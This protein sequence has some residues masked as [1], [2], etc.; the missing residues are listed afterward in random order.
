MNTLRSDPKKP[1]ALENLLSA[2]SDF[3]NTTE[4]DSPSSRWHSG[5]GGTYILT[6]ISLASSTPIPLVWRR[7]GSIGSSNDEKNQIQIS[8][9]TTPESIPL[10]PWK[11]IWTAFGDKW[12]PCPNHEHL[13]AEIFR[14]V[15]RGNFNASEGLTELNVVVKEME[16]CPIC[17]TKNHT[18]T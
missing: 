10:K 11:E 12:S 15:D 13:V 8:L 16:K 6:P 14:A 2:I 1:T 9:P 5:G 3:V 17:G 18:T 7:R 4:S